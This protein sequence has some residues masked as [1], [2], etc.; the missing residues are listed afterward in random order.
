MV[1]QKKK[2]ATK[3]TVMQP[4]TTYEYHIVTVEVPEEHIMFS[5]DPAIKQLMT[6]KIEETLNKFAQDG[7][8]LHASGL[9]HAPTLILEREKL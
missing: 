1:T 6:T 3:R 5:A 9:T 2:T 7:W 8:K 4:V